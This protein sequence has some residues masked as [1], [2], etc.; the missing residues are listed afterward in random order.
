[1]VG[2]VRTRSEPPTTAVTSTRG[3]RVE[4]P[5]EEENEIVA[6]EKEDLKQRAPE[7][8]ADKAVA[9]R[10]ARHARRGSAPPNLDALRHAI[11]DLQLP[12]GA[13]EPTPTPRVAPTLTKKTSSYFSDL[14]AKRRSSEAKK[15]VSRGLAFPQFMDDDSNDVEGASPSPPHPFARPIEPL[16]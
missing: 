6:P 4:P 1:M 12:T 15:P 2:H 8:P 3:S 10:G 5:D 14:F 9:K 11:E 7:Q 16:V 13:E